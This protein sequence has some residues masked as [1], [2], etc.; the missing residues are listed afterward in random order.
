MKIVFKT[1]SREMEV[2]N[3][4][5]EVDYKIRDLLIIAGRVY[6]DS[7]AC[8]IVDAILQSLDAIGARVADMFRNFV[9]KEPERMYAHT[10]VEGSITLKIAKVR[11]KS[12]H[13]QTF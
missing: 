6:I 3:I 8:L 10:A 1:G 7:S 9:R 12:P 4:M 13:A 11:R 5:A 2:V